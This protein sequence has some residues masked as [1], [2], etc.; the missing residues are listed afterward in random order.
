MN[1][2]ILIPAREAIK[3]LLPIGGFLVIVLAVLSVFRIG[4]IIW[5][6]PRVAAVDGLVYILLQGVRFD[7][8]LLGMLLLV[9]ATLTP[10]FSTNRFTL[11]VWQP[12]LRTY[13]ALCLALIVF[14]EIS[15]P[16]FINQYDARPNIVFVEYLKYPKEVFSTLWAAYKLQL[17]LAFGAIPVVFYIGARALKRVERAVAPVK[18]W[19]ALLLS[20]LVL[21][22]AFAM[23]RSTLDHRAVNPSTVAFSPDPMVNDL[24]MSSAY[25]VLYAIYES[26]YDA[27][28]GVRYGTMPKEQVIKLVRED[29]RIDDDAFVSDALPTLH[30]QTA[31]RKRARPLN[32][33]IVLE[34]SLGAEFVGCLG[35]L[36]VTPNWCELSKKGL[37]FENMFATGTRS[38]RG[39]EALI[40]GFTP[41]PARS[42]VKL[43]GS[44]REFFTIAQLLSR[45]GYDT[46]FIYGGESQFDNMRRFFM[47]NGF[48]YVIDENDYENPIFYGSWGVS[49]EDLFNR[50]QQYFEAQG[51]RPFFSLVFTSSNHSPF[52]YPEG[53]IELYD[54]EKATVNNAVK[55]A[56]YALGKFFEKAM[57]S[58][59]WKNTVFLVTSDHNSRVYGAALIPI[60][61]FRIPALILGADIEPAVFK[62]I[63]SQIDLPPTLL[64]LI[65]ISGTHPM[66]GHDLTR[67]LFTR[68]P[69]RA[70]MQYGPR[71]GYMEGNNI[72]IM[73]KDRPIE[74][75]VYTGGR[76]LPAQAP[77][78]ALK[79]KAL[80]HSL[81]S[82]MAYLEHLYRLP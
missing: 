81:W 38:V 36:P 66:I 71:Q 20:P 19:A 67:E 55:Y 58:S 52:Q 14:M 12:V 41:T 74:Q 61:R 6:W 57:R 24:S 8:V 28:G 56:D 45:R 64:S 53:R 70:I 5:Q 51:D 76:L 48:K 15:T 1:S 11:T 62:P 46:S 9:P 78:E 49:D 60:E 21:V 33:V 47:N 16:S 4:L 77:S 43:P 39:L 54:K 7:L 29:M 59:Y 65:G 10:V 82:S 80:A 79:Q 25:T 40:S 73:E 27:V 34:E 32:L 75:Y 23:A 72:V 2:A 37:W 50:A 63:A 68:I 22:T 18:W 31:T 30:K 42:V 3:S 44:Q 35:G 17:F 69:G 13:L 26:K